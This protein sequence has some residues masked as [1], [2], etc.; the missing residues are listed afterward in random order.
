[1]R[2]EDS[3]AS[4]ET[5]IL[6]W[7]PYVMRPFSLYGRRPFFDVMIV[8][9]VSLTHWVDVASEAVLR[10]AIEVCATRPLT[11]SWF[12]LDVDIDGRDGK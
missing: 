12:S 8:A 2:T 3:I 9:P 5:K 10:Q 4:A 6:P 1:M 7:I 11:D